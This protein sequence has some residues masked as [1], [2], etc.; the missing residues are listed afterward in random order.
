MVRLSDYHQIELAE[1][2]RHLIDRPTEN[3]YALH[4]VFVKTANNQPL[5]QGELVIAGR[6]TREDHS[7]AQEFPV[8]FRKTYYPTSLHPDP[9]EEFEKAKIASEILK[10]PPPIGFSPRVF[11]NSFIP[12]RPFDRCSPF[13]PGLP[14]ERYIKMAVKAPVAQLIGLWRILEDAFDQVRCLHEKGMSHGDLELH[15]IV[16]SSS[17]IKAFLIDFEVAQ[18]EKDLPA[19]DWEKWKQKDLHNILREAVFIQCG[20]GK[21]EGLLAE[22]A[23]ARI[24]DLFEKSEPFY[25]NLTPVGVT[26]V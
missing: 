13:T 6:R 9:E 21:Q 14:D 24:E 11:R 2:Y 1:E 26:E 17:P 25:S 7:M 23:N 5:K 19:E 22:T 16:I 3:D 12:G 10:A 8:H 18:F 15:N 20:L 4:T